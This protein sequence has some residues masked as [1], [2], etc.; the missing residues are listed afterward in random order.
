MSVCDSETGEMI[1]KNCKNLPFLDVET[2][3]CSLSDDLEELGHEKDQIQWNTRKTK[4]N[5]PKSYLRFC[6]PENPKK[7]CYLRTQDTYSLSSKKRVIQL[8]EV[9]FIS[10]VVCIII[11]IFFLAENNSWLQQ[12]VSQTFF[13]T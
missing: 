10:S 12:N 11:K 3:E 7:K 1:V 2:G 8:K 9:N 6:P 5:V 13:N 4:F